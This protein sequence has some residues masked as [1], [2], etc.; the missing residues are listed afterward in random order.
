MI[1]ET[2]GEL[3]W[4]LGCLIIAV[5]IGSFLIIRLKY[6]I[7]IKIILLALFY[8]LLLTIAFYWN[9]GFTILFIVVDPIGIV[10]VFFQLKRVYQYIIG[11]FITLL[12]LIISI[13]SSVSESYYD[14]AILFFFVTVIL[15]YLGYKE[16]KDL[17]QQNKPFRPFFKSK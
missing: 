16:L 12:M 15:F 17:K 11:G 14:I 5:L 1:L 13:F 4:M 10:Y 3:L 8:V 9:S 7:Q 2:N 6:K